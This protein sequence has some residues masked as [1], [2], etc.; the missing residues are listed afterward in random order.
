MATAMVLSERVGP[1]AGAAVW[2]KRAA[3]VA[4][5]VI[6]M[7]IAAKAKIPFW[8][9]PMTLQTLVV[10]SVGAAYGPRLGLATMLA[11]LAVGALGAD[12][13]TN[14]S[15]DLSGIAYMLGGTGGYLVGFAL[16][17]VVLGVLARRG[18][19]RSIVW[20][21]LAMLI[22]SVAI[23]APGLAWLGHLH[24]GAELESGA[25]VGWATILDWGLWPFLAA[26]ALKLAAAALLFPLAWRA[27]GEA[28]A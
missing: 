24:L 6:A 11:Y 5:G 4:L 23:Y 7:A 27:V 15:A 2:A 22:G 12:V 9:V 10:L 16:A 3:L 17:T 18:W 20:M 8:P 21:A 14:S 26:D 13:F 25:I 19:D 1:T 28:R